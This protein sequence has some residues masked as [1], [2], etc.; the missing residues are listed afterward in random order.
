MALSTYL[1][2]DISRSA[3]AFF[4]R[5]CK[6]GSRRTRNAVLSWPVRS[7]VIIV[8]LYRHG[9]R[10]RQQGRRVSS[11]RAPQ[12]EVVRDITLLPGEAQDLVFS[13]GARRR[14]QDSGT[15][16]LVPC[17]Y[18][19]TLGY[20]FVRGSGPCPGNSAPVHLAYP[21]KLATQRRSGASAEGTGPAI[22]S[23]RY[24]LPNGGTG[25]TTQTRHSPE[26]FR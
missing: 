6:P 11:G 10:V 18:L 15:D 3:A 17:S 7:F 21:L 9:N 19:R 2:S 23:P 1:A 22:W 5:R 4:A 8:L 24:S 25:S 20:P 14:A 26:R 16:E 12:E 13:G